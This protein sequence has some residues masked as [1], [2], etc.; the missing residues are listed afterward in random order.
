MSN[1]KCPNKS[2]QWPFM[3]M[4]LT[5]CT[6]FSLSLWRTNFIF[7]GAPGEEDGNLRMQRPNGNWGTLRFVKRGELTTTGLNKKIRQLHSPTFLRILAIFGNVIHE[8]HERD[9]L[10]R[11]VFVID[12][13]SAILGNDQLQRLVEP[14]ISTVRRAKR[15]VT[16]SGGSW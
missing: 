3:D 8:G 15:R 9:T 13:K 16:E 1:F 4:E 5:L 2:N 10:G 14:A 7:S 12:T 6:N 11:R